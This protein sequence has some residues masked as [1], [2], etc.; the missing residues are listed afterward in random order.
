MYSQA[1][2]SEFSN[3]KIINQGK[4]DTKCFGFCAVSWFCSSRLVCW[5]Q[6]VLFG[7]LHS[8]DLMLSRSLVAGV[9]EHFLLSWCLVLPAL[10]AVQVEPNWEDALTDWKDWFGQ[11]GP[12]VFLQVLTSGS[13]LGLLTRGQREVADTNQP[14]SVIS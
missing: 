1:A 6:F 11:T 5:I 14:V 2:R 7:S 8:L 4:F 12:D 13:V 10:A 9:V 3:I